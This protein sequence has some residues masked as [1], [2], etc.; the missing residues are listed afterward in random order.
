V[1]PALSGANLQSAVDAGT[2]YDISVRQS[3]AYDSRHFVRAGLALTAQRDA[4]T[5]KGGI[6]AT[7]GD[8]S[9]AGINAQLA[10]AYRF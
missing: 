9:S 3:S 6:R 2:L 10:V 7:P 8:R 5:L 1:F 4:F